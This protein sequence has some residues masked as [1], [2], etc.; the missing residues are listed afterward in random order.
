VE[1]V[2]CCCSYRYLK[3]LGA[4]IRVGAGY[5]EKPVVE[6]FLAGFDTRAVAPLL[7]SRDTITG[8]QRHHYWVPETPLLGSRDTITGFQRHHYWVPETPFLGSRH[9]ILQ[10]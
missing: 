9:A 3:T 1:Y 6:P 4:Q 5:A 2:P 10:R 7:G 8:F